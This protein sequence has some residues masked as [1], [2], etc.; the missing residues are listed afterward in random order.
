MPSAGTTNPNPLT[1]TLTLTL[2]VTLTLTLTLIRDKTHGLTE[3]AEDEEG[4]E[5]SSPSPSR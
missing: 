2:T 3:D 4:A 1:L 5:E